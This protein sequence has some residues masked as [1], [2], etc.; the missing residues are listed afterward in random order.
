MVDVW[1]V[2]VYAKYKYPKAFDQGQ[3]VDTRERRCIEGEHVLTVLD[4]VTERTYT[5]TVVQARGGGYDTHGYTVDP[6]LHFIHPH[7]GKVVVNIPFRC[8]LPKG[9]EG[10]LVAGL[11]LSSHRDATP[12]VRMQ[13]DVQNGGYAAGVAAAMAARSNTLVR[14]IDVRVLQEHLVQIGSLTA[15]VLT[16]KESHPLPREVVA[17]AVKKIAKGDQAAVVFAQPADSLSLLRE[18]YGA[19]QGDEKFDYAMAMAMLG[20]RTG[21]DLIIDRVSKT[22]DWGQGLELQGDGAVRQRHES[23]GLP[24]GGAGAGGAIGARCR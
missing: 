9:L 19:A 4:E 15:S 18:A 7:T 11:G 10:I 6:Y 23:A 22:A 2:Y 24:V 12:L 8:F 17:E 21:V 16:D 14:H 13:A 5:D 20:D 3:L 1:H